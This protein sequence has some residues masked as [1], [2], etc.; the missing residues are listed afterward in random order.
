M[1]LAVIELQLAR[2]VDDDA[3]V[4]GH[5]AGVELHDREAAPDPVV[6]AR[7]LER[8]DLGP[9]HP[10]H[11]LGVDIHREPV[12][13]I[14]RKD[15]EIHARLVAPCLGH[16]IDDHLR[17]PRQIFLGDRHGELQLHKA[18]ADAVFGFVEAAETV[19]G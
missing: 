13:R 12:Q 9:I 18:D 3:G 2:I 1:H 15:D 4:V 16:E 8:R 6:Q 10:A 19:H 17:L 14:F 5:A 7:I 11:D